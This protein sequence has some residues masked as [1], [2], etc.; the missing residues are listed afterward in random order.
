MLCALAVLLHELLHLIHLL[1]GL[2]HVPLHRL[3]QIVVL[4][5]LQDLRIGLQRLLFRIQDELEF[6]L[7][8]VFE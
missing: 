1:L 7:V 3:A 5:F 8:E 2:L 4:Y 6:C